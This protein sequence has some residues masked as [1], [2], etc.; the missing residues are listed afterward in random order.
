MRLNVN[1]LLHTPGSGQ[2]FHFEMDL[3]DQ[4]FDGMYPVEN[5]VVVDGRIHNEAGMLL[6]DL[7]ADTTLHCV[8]DRCAEDFDEPKTVSYSCVLAEEKQFEDSEDIVLLENDEVDLEEI[9]R[10]AFILAMDTKH[11]CS[12]DCKGLCSGCGVNLNRE[13]CR[14]K[15][16][17]DPRLAALAKLLEQNDE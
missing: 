5:P 8:C 15:R 7:Q 13:A 12:E 4:E 6:L 2:D 10:V 11:L 17:V 16:Q 9:A 14:C 1:K 3:R